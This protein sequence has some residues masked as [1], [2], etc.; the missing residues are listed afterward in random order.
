LPGTGHTTLPWW[1]PDQLAAWPS[2]AAWLHRLQPHSCKPHPARHPRPRSRSLSVGNT[3][4]HAPTARH[5]RLL[6]VAVPAHRRQSHGNRWEIA[7]KG[8][9]ACSKRLTQPAYAWVPSLACK[10]ASRVSC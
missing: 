5:H 6:G 1:P 2:R 8:V 4:R 3:G 10:T 7:I 9:G